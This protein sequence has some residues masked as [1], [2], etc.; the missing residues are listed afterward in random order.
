MNPNNGATNVS[1]TSPSYR[2]ENV[3]GATVYRILVSQNSDFSG[4]SETTRSCDS[5]CFTDTISSTSYNRAL[6]NA[7]FTYYWK[8]RAGN[9][10]SGGIWS[11][12]SSFRT[13]PA[14][15]VLLLLHGLNSDGDTWERFV[16]NQFADNCPQLTANTSNNALINDGGTAQANND[17][18]LCYRL[19]FGAFDRVAEQRQGVENITC[20]NGNNCS[21][22]WSTF[23]QLGQE[24]R[25]AVRF[26][27][28]NHGQNAQVVL[29]GHSRGGL[30]A[31]AFLQGNSTERANVVGLVTTGTPH[32]GSPLGRIWQYLTDNCVDMDGNGSGESHNNARGA[33]FGSNCESDWEAAKVVLNRSGLDIR[34]PSVNYLSDQSQ[35]IINLNS[36]IGH[37]PNISYA[38][39]VYNGAEFG[40][41]ARVP[42]MTN[43]YSI[44]DRQGADAGDQVSKGNNSAQEAILGNANNTGAPPETDAYLGDGIVPAT[45]QRLDNI[46]GWSR[47]LVPMDERNNGRV[48]RGDGIAT[49][50]VLHTEEPDQVEDITNALNAVYGRIGWN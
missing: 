14:S 24:V 34:A 48:S 21:G 15:R 46:D 39:L 45:R 32:R 19:D 50:G 30:A 13:A 4:Y 28:D 38:T 27:R 2:W 36:V 8:V 10:N 31:R 42:L 40:I 26:I 7:D 47:A 1:Q 20:D 11:Q 25:G 41:L 5:T 44:F 37:L 49:H 16:G 12:E 3:S 35:A 43:G 33:W 18:I 22:D 17:G 9:P 29:L 6:N 23:Q